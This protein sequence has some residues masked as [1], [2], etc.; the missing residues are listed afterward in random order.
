VTRDLNQREWTCRDMESI[1]RQ[2][3]LAF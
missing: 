2:V 3:H 1:L